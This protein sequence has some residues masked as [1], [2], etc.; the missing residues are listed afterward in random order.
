MLYYRLGLE[1]NLFEEGVVLCK[2]TLCVSCSFLKFLVV[3]LFKAI[4]FS[5]LNSE[6]FTGISMGV[7]PFMC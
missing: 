6:R 5:G 1:V 2:H 3:F 4:A 7:K